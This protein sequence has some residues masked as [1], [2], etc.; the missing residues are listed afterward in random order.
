MLF[1]LIGNVE[2]LFEVQLTK[3]TDNRR[4]NVDVFIAILYQE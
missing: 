3:V 4:K 2:R 1:Y